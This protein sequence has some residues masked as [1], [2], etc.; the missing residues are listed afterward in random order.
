MLAGFLASISM[1][2]YAFGAPVLVNE[3]KGIAVN[4]G[5]LAQPWFQMT[6]PAASGQGSKGIGA[7]DGKSPSFDFFLRRVR[8]MAWGSISR[9]LAFFVETDQPNLGKGGDFSSSMFI[10]DAFLTYT[11]MPELKLDAGMMLV[12]LSR[13]T[14]EGAVGL[15]AIDYHAELVRFPA[16]KIFR[17]VG[18]Q[19][20]GLLADGLV[21]YRFGIFEGVRAGAVPAIVQPAPP[22]PP[23]PVPPPLNDSGLPRLA[24]QLRYNIMGSEG[25]FFLKG[26][27]FSPKPIVS[28]GFGADFQA[29]AVYKNGNE[30]STY[31]A[32]SLDVFAEYPFSTEDEIIAK[33]NFFNYSA[34]ATGIPGST[35]LAQGGIAFYVEGGYRH[36]FIEP[37]A[38]VEYLKA[39]EGSLSI[40]SPHAG[41]NFWLNQHTFNVKADFGYRKTDTA[42]AAGATTTT[43]DILATVQAQVFF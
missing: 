28:V 12:P 33:A 35:A 14:I 41:A 27:Y 24:A 19:A 17:D 32:Q 36:G 23:I 25:D 37:L 43:K 18:V 8:L 40:L 1:G 38:Y 26:I 31:F 29:K 6:M 13:H 7:P 5:V 21:H 16:G 15:N 10:Q 34:G 39:G 9:E 11:F 42:G 30:P 22:A 3:E 20:R 4:V 2:S